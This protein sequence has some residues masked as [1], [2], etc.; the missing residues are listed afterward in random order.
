MKARRDRALRTLYLILIACATLPASLFLYASWAN[1]SSAF[2]VADEDISRALDIAA[3]HAQAVL[4]SVDV[5]M[6]SVEQIT[7]GRSPESLRSEE[8]ELNA[9]LKEMRAAIPDI[10]SI[11]LFDATGRPIASSLLIPVPPGL[12]VS[13]RDFFVSQRDVGAPLFVGEVFSPSITTRN[14]FAV[15]KRRIDGTGNFSGVTEVSIQPAAFESFFAGIARG[16]S[17]SLALIREDGSLLARFPVPASVGIKLD[18]SSGFEGLISQAPQGGRYTS[19]SAIDKVERR[20]ATRK[21][22]GFPI[23][24]TASLTTADI[25]HGWVALMASHLIFGVP[26][27]LLLIALVLVAMGRTRA[28]YAEAERREVLEA[29]L[30]QSQKMDAIGQLTGGIAHDF[31]NLLMVISGYSEFLLDRLGPDPALRGPAQEIAG[32]SQRASSLTRQLLA[33]SRKQMLAPKILDLNGVVTENLKMLTRVIGEDIELIMVPAPSLGSVRADAGQI[34][35]VIMNLA[36]NARDAMPSGGKLTIETSNISLDEEYARFHAPLRAGEYVMLSISDTGFGMDSETQSHI[37]EPFFTTKGPK[38]TGLGLSTVYGIIKQSGGYIW[39]FSETGKGTTFK[40]YLPR[41][42]ERV[43]PAQVVAIDEGAV[44]EPGTETILLAEDEIN[45]RYL[46]RQ[47]LEKQGYRVIEAADGAVAMQI[48]VAHEGVI[49]LLLTDVIMPGMNGRELA[50]RISEIRP[51]T[52]VLYMSG[53]TENVIGHN[54]TL[55]AGVRL[56][57]KPFTLRELKSKVREVL[58]SIPVGTEAD[59]SVRRAQASSERRPEQPTL[60]R[61]PRFQLHLPLKYRRLDEDKWHDGETRDISRSGLLFQAGD[62]TQPH[63]LQPNVQ[64]EINLVLPAEIA[65]L[66]PTEVVC[67]GEIV[68]TVKTAGEEMPPALAA[69]ILQYHFQHGAQLPRA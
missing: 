19:V 54:G 45:L 55:D 14:I 63:L 47:F 18:A 42:A 51:Q 44:S 38:G 16:T 7:R 8:S 10:E 69:K 12:D 48:A 64:L 2:E 58:D 57:Q 3:G 9:R 4:Q 26:A 50:Q 41:V 36:V 52:K 46:A 30:R 68:R 39:V 35:Q 20:F 40:I 15:S 37:F 6:N 32:A 13:A 29:N 24:V 1:Y 22:T 27:T 53:Y 33:F 43:E 28:F 49:H 61:A 65:G 62:L 23:Y 31:N 66:S 17:S 25:R 5:T 21:L 11:W 59:T 67:R 34:D 56:L 60:S